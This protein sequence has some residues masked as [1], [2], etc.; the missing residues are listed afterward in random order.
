MRR[1]HRCSTLQMRKTEAQGLLVPE[2][3][4]INGEAGFDLGSLNSEFMFVVTTVPQLFM[5]Q[6]SLN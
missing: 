2:H 1:Q 3:M 6:L 5:I 4:T